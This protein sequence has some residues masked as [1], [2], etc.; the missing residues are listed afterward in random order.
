MA[1]YTL[2]LHLSQTIGQLR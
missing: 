1:D 2:N